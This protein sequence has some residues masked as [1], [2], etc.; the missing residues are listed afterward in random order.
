MQ[1]DFGATS[2]VIEPPRMAIKG[3]L[4]HIDNKESIHWVLD[5]NIGKVAYSN[6]DKASFL[7]GEVTNGV[8][9]KGLHSSLK[10]VFNQA[11]LPY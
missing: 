5:E 1:F 8:W 6:N 9:I 11:S 7:D 10:T 4:I 2:F 3:I